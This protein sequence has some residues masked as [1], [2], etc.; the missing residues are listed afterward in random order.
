[1]VLGFFLMIL[2]VCLI[3]VVGGIIAYIYRGSIDSEIQKS[4]N[5]SIASNYGM[6][7]NL[8]KTYAINFLQEQYKCCGDVDYKS[9]EKSEWYKSN[10]TDRIQTYVPD[11]CCITPSYKCGKRVH[12]SNIW[13]NDYDPQHNGC[14]MSL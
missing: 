14:Y 6:E 4:L 5:V 13:R 12:P 10:S 3:E 1:M 11:S 9:W 7:G 2:I 8:K